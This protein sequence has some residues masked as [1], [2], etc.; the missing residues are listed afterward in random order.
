MGNKEIDEVKIK[1]QIDFIKIYHSCLKQKKLYSIVCGIAFILATVYVFSIPR[2]YTTE[3]RLA[4]EESSGSSSGSFGAIASFVKGKLGSSGSDDA[5][6]PELYP[7]LF[8]SNEFVVKLFNIKVFTQ[9]D[10]TAMRWADYLV[11][12]ERM[13]WWQMLQGAIMRQIK[14]IFKGKRQKQASREDIIDPFR[15]TFDQTG[16]AEAIRAS[17]YCDVDKKTSVISIKSKAQDPVVSA[18]VADSVMTHLKEFIFEYRTSKAR[19]DVA[20]TEKILEEAHQKYEDCKKKYIDYAESHNDL[21]QPSYTT[22]MENLENEMQLAYDAYSQVNQQ[23]QL[24]KAKVQERT[25]VFT[26]IQSAT[27][28]LF[29]AGPKRV[30][31]ILLFVL[32]AFAATTIYIYMT[33]NQQ[34]SAADEK[35]P[36]SPEKDQ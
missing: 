10:T 20:Y 21:Y 16:I 23:L 7:D 22:Q 19:I 9:K 11:T 5:I 18:L 34:E 4:P 26:T 3:V 30:K 27:V 15:L 35:T 29:S 12:K 32:A 17:V 31:S 24:A 25:P 36:K 6:Y 8:Y 2:Y 33:Y 13:P 28:P 14:Q 1:N